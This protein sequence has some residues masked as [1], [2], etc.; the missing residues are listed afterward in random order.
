MDELFDFLVRHCVAEPILNIIHCLL[1]ADD[2]V[3]ISTDRQLFIKK[4]N[5]MLKYFNDNS[6]SLNFPKSSYLIINPKEDDLK[7]DLHLEFGTIE[8][9]ASYVYLGVVVSDTGSMS[10]D[11]EKFV[12]KKRGNVAIKYN[13]FLRKNF[14]APLP[15]KLQVLDVCV[16]TTLT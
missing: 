14:L 8:Y 10:H 7:C 6:M 12:K 9:K 1:H 4:C 15:V 2:T 5:T 11:I 13:N 3:I 16:S